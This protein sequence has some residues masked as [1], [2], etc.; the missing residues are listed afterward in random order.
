MI[1]KAWKPLEIVCYADFAN[2]NYVIV[3]TEIDLIL[4]EI[5]DGAK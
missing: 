4:K 2:W 3:C 5:M 1:M